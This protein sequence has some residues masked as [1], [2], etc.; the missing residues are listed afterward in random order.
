MNAERKCSGG[1]WCPC[2]ACKKTA[3]REE[4]RV[5]KT[6]MKMAAHMGGKGRISVVLGHRS[7]E[8][9]EDPSYLSII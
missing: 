8:A 3:M 9:F 1:V 6:A 5:T 7:G 4:A 2:P